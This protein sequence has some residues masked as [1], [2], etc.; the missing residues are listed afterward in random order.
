[1]T[2]LKNYEQLKSTKIYSKSTNGNKKFCTEY[3]LIILRPEVMVIFFY[4]KLRC[5]AKNSK[6]LA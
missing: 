4:L 2:Y 5:F 6:L 1:M 3:F